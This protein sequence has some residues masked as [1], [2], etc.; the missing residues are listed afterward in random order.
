MNHGGEQEET[1]GVAPAP[2][3]LATSEYRY[4]GVDG[5][6]TICG[7]EYDR[8][9][10]GHKNNPYTIFTHV[11]ESDFVELDRACFRRLDYNT[12]FRKLAITTPTAPHEEAG[13]RFSALVGMKAQ[14]MGVWRLLSSRGS[15]TM[16]TQDR[17]KEPDG[18]WGPR[19]RYSETNIKW[20]TVVLEVAFSEPKD[21]VKGDA[22]WWL[23]QSNTAVL[24]AITID[25]KRPSGDVYVTLWE[26]GAAQSRQHPRPEAKAVSTL[27]IFRGQHGNPARLEG[28]DIAVPFKDMLLRDPD[29]S[30]GEADFIFSQA[31]L[32]EIAEDV[33]ADMGLP[34]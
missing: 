7:R 13:T 4:P 3:S 19:Q 23:Y 15:T 10:A 12:S 11:S 5:A 31:E 17:R 29:T 6:K 16:E 25:I 14:E 33:W 22:W 20:P 28:T 26:R 24:K 9:L 34:F 21:K 32:L 8:F 27:D 1:G 30:H 18:S 2:L